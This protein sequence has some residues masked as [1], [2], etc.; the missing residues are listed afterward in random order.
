LGLR[1]G[2]FSG[3]EGQGDGG[4]LFVSTPLLEGV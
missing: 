4:R 2:L 1:S 3:T